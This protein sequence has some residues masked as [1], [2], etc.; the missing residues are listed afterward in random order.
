MGLMKFNF[1]T[2]L[3]KSKHDVPLWLWINTFKL[4]QEFTVLFYSLATLSYFWFHTCLSCRMS[5]LKTYSLKDMWAPCCCEQ[6][7]S[8][9]QQ[10][11]ISVQLSTKAWAQQ[12]PVLIQYLSR[13]V[14][15][16]QARKGGAQIDTNPFR[17]P[18]VGGCNFKCCLQVQKL[19]SGN[20]LV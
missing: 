18:G 7:A 5:G 8:L 14:W 19:W 15:S 13:K 16:M 20:I 1:Q 12:L 9:V 2:L 3:Y 10:C 11:E 4:A 17:L 6:K